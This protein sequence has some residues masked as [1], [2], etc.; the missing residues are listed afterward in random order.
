MQG[1]PPAYL[2]PLCWL[3][4]A[5]AL[6]DS[7]DKPRPVA[8]AP[9]PPPPPK[10]EPIPVSE[11]VVEMPPKVVR[12]PWMIFQLPTK[13]E[14]LLTENK[15]AY[16]MFVDRTT[17]GIT[18]QVS[19]GGQYGFVRDPKMASDGSIVYSRF[20]EGIDVAPVKRDAKGEPIDEVFA[21]ADGRVVYANAAAKSNYGNYVIVEHSTSDGPFYSLYAHLHHLHVVREQKVARGVV[22]GIM[23]HTGTGIDRRRAHTHVE[24][25]LLLNPRLAIWQMTAPPAVVGN[26]TP[27][28]PGTPVPKPPPPP[29]LNGQNLVGLDIAGWLLAINQEPE[30]KLSEFIHRSEPYFKI[31]TPCLGQ[32]LEIVQRYPWLRAPG[33]IGQSWEISIAASSV[34]LRIEPLQEKVEFT[35]VSWVQPF[36]GNHAWKSREMLSGSGSTATLSRHGQEYLKLLLGQ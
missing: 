2:R 7:C 14:A 32:E 26:T 34:P 8:P 30:L 22:L 29:T 31:R 16:F 4:L 24:L 10:V 19:E 33:P 6:L 11:P 5:A 35:T 1:F 13:N 28:P 3:I 23:G 17:N 21:I 18:T 15:D 27:P 9:P 12:K 20:H 25:N 36:V